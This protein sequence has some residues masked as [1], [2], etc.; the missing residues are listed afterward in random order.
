MVLGLHV[1]ATSLTICKQHGGVPCALLCA[2]FLFAF[3]WAK[4][5]M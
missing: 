5:A 1:A 2:Q 4:Q 3:S